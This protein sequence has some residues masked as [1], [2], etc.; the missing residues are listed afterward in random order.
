M[1]WLFQNFALNFGA[2]N[3][4]DERRVQNLCKLSEAMI[5]RESRVWFVLRHS[6]ISM[7]FENPSRRFYISIN[8]L[9]L[10]KSKSEEK[11][12]KNG[13]GFISKKSQNYPQKTL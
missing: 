3:C 1:W 10:K 2:V 11:I 5:L 13:I 12:P 8:Y 4:V 6:N 9:I 7:P